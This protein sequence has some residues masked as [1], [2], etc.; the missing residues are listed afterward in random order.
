MID[1]RKGPMTKTRIIVF[2]LVS[3]LALGG[4]TM[5]GAAKKKKYKTTIEAQYDAGSS[6]DPYDPYANAKFK[7]KVESRKKF[8]VKERKVVVKE[9]G[10]GE[11]IGSEFTSEKGKFQVDASGIDRGTYKVTAK[12]KKK[13]KKK[14][15]KAAT[16]TVK[17]QG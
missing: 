7:G 11:K 8:C 3:V 13:G 17:V 2:A 14:I 1:L 6:T 4:A 10:S 16:A 9:K 15:C 5:A 12:K